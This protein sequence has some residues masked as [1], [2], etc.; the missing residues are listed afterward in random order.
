MFKF[1][2]NL[3]GRFINPDCLSVYLV[4]YM[5]MLVPMLTPQIEA[6]G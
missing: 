3:I 5:H 2:T 6:E 1:K 4:K